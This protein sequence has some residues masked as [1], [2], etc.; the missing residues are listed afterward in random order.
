M[1]MAVRKIAISLDPQLAQQ[2][3]DAA[4]ARGTTVSGW[5]GRAAANQLQQEKLGAF[6]DTW[7]AEDGP[8]T[9]DEFATVERVWPG[10]R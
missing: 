7:E 4:N 10:S 6:L 8:F 2:V 1:G 3:R 5:L 9:E